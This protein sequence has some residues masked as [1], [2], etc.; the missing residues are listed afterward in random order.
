MR[1]PAAE[2]LADLPLDLD[3]HLRVLLQELL[4][5]LASLAD[6]RLSKREES[7]TLPDHPHFRSHVQ[8]AAFPGYPLVE[9][10]VELR[11][12]EGRC[13]LVLHHLDLRSV[14]NHL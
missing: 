13:H 1:L 8:E 4:G 14:V 2:S 5:V 9:H 6:A 7:P 11:D 10:Y 3:G 12:S